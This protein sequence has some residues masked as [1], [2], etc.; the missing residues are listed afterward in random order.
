MVA[1]APAPVRLIRAEEASDRAA[2]FDVNL[3]AFG[4]DTEAR[5][6]DAVRDRATVSLV[7]VEDGAIVGH[8]LFSPVTVSGHTF[9]GLAPMAVTPER[10]R[11][12]IGSMLVHAGIEACRARGDRAIF[13]LGHAEYYPRFG[14]TPAAA[15]GLHYKSDAFDPYFFVLELDRGALGGVSGLVEYDPAFDEA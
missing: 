1:G 15:R 6:V 2:V 7:A 11:S 8:I 9:T 3:R 14:F 13:V 12:G 10:Q 4:G 5:L